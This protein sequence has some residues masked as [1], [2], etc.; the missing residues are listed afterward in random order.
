MSQSLAETV[1]ALETLVKIP[2]QY[3]I[4]STKDRL[5]CLSNEGGAFA[6][7]SVDPASGLK[8]RI[9]PGPVEQSATPRHDANSVFY[10]KDMAKGAELHKVFMAD[11]L[12]EA[13]E[14]LAVD[15]PPMRIEGLANAGTMVAFT[16]A[17]KEEMAVYTSKS[18]SLEKRMKLDSFAFVTDVNHTYIVGYGVLAKNPRSSEIF[19]FDMVR[20]KQAVYTPKTGSVNK[21][22]LLRE[23]RVLFESDHTGK[24]RLHVYDIET[25]DIAA[26][27]ASTEDYLHYD[28][29]EHPYYGWTDDGRVWFVGKK[30]G[31]AKA[32]VDGDEVPTPPGFLWGF[33]LLNGRAYA[34]HTTV[35]QPMKVLEVDRQTGRSRVVLDNPLPPGMAE[36]LGQSRFIRY[37]SFD[38]RSIPALVVD[39][40]TGVPRR[41]ITYV[42][43]GPW[44][45][46]VNSWG[47]FIG[48]LAMV[49]YN[50]IAPNYRGSTGYG[51]DYRNLDIGDPGGGDLKDVASAA[52]W[53]KQSRLAT[54]LAILGYSYGGYTT[55]LALGKE[56]ELWACGVA[57]APIA[58]WKESYDLSDA[59]YR[60][61]AKI[62]FDNKMELFEERSPITCVKNV[63]RPLCIISSQNDSRTPMKPVLKYAMALLNQRGKF[64]LHS[65][66]DMGHVVR[67]T[68]DVMDIVLPVI[69]FL[70]KQFPAQL[71]H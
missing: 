51:E 45:D 3:L 39:H 49:G 35:V 34:S 27:P 65:V 70:D 66:P 24:N 28:P 19:L 55:L 68:Q 5:I 14:T 22:P 21:T 29:T 58:D 26:A 12:G 69:T 18:G 8:S 11:A 10:T 53:A 6:L 50:V 42:H 60:D 1:K 38:G 37:E 41:T 63:R 43:G 13:N 30:D 64:E 56:P 17:T 71:D 48:S 59:E 16:G 46:V 32:F 33:A 40:G 62:L 61:F 31:E 23:S 20:N 2:F 4:G 7:W 25:G 9:T 44:A 54:E 36:R 52:L 47:V 15:A 67:T 57:G